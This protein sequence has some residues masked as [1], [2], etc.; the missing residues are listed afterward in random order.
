MPNDL[1][2]L[3]FQ[4]CYSLAKMSGERR[5][6]RQATYGIGTQSLG[7]ESKDGG[8]VVAAVV[9]DQGGTFN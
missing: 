9:R 2:L 3:L 8:N 5:E 1:S 6:P 7:T 4:L